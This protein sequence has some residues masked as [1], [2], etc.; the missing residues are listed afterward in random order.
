MK[1]APINIRRASDSS[2][3]AS[4]R[5]LTLAKWSAKLSR[6]SRCRRAN[7]F[8]VRVNATSAVSSSSAITRRI[9][10]ADRD[11]CSGFSSPGTNSPVTTRPGSGR[12]RTRPRVTRALTRRSR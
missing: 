2:T 6:R 1:Y 3:P 8:T 7:S 4:R 11:S 10:P 5:W 12:S 9:T